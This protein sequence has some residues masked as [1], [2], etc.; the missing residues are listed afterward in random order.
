MNLIGAPLPFPD[1]SFSSWLTRLT[2]NQGA[3]I[4]G[5]LKFLGL[6]GTKDPD[7]SMASNKGIDAIMRAGVEPSKLAL[8]HWMFSGVRALNH[9]G[10]QYLLH[11]KTGKARFRV[12]PVCLWQPEGKYYPVHWRFK[13]WIWCPIHDCALL[14][15]CPHCRS[16]IS[17]PV[18]MQSS[19]R[20][21]QGVAALDRCMCCSQKISAPPSAIAHPL[22]EALLHD[23]ELLCVRNGRAVLAALLHREFRVYDQP[24]SWPVRELNI[25]QGSGVFPTNQRLFNDQCF[26]ERIEDRK[27]KGILTNLSRHSLQ[28]TA[29]PG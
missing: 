15:L 17:L 10:D 18:T 22:Q 25:I 27:R 28:K 8:A 12:C 4:T 14:G 5:L 6:E 9:R 23:W 26:S 1:E 3:S 19:G 13:S 21:G 2:L 24:R 16:E 20:D 29:L 11:T 7:L